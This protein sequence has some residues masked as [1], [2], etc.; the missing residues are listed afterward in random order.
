V[1]VDPNRLLAY[2]V[3][4]TDLIMAIRNA[5]LDVGGGAIEMAETEFMVRTTGGYIAS[6]ED[7]ESIVVMATPEGTP[8]RVMDLAEVRLGPEMRRGMAEL[9]GEGEVPAA[10]LSCARRERPENHR[11]GS[12]RSWRN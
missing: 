9:D 8:I 6:V 3:P 4:M 7:L 2:D 10:S 11:A 5:N 1:A 12:T